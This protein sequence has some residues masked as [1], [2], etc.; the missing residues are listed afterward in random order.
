MSLRI[1]YCGYFIGDFFRKN[2]ITLKG[3]EKEDEHGEYTFFHFS[4]CLPS[5]KAHSR[6]LIFIHFGIFSTRHHPQVLLVFVISF[7]VT[8]LSEIIFLWEKPSYNTLQAAAH[9]AT[10]VGCLL[11]VLSSVYGFLNI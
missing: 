5:T 6:L 11:A 10:G 7:V 3:K 4:Q 1:A 9:V 8:R 2:S